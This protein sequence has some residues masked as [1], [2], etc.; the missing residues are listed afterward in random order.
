MRAEAM[1]TLPC[2]V[3]RFMFSEFMS[4]SISHAYNFNI[5]SQGNPPPLFFNDCSKYFTTLICMPSHMH[6]LTHAC[7]CMSSHMHAHACP[8]TCM[9]SHM[10]AHACPHTCMPS[11][12]HV[13]THACPHTCMHVLTHACPHTCM[14]SHMHVLTHACPHT[15][16]RGG[17][18]VFVEEGFDLRLS[19]LYVQLSRLSQPT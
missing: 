15:C 17:S 11:H 14:S 4:C 18:R 10:H 13:L 12:M 3:W 19:G 9:P 16:S 1:K 6:A 8:H 2:Q 5:A 7:T